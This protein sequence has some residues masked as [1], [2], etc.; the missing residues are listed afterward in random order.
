[1]KQ[2]KH[3]RPLSEIIPDES[4]SSLKTIFRVVRIGCL[5][6]IMLMVLK[7]T[8][9]HLGHS[10]ALTADGFHSLNDVAADLIMLVF[11]GISYREADERYSY[12]YGK[13]ET[14]ASFLISLFLIFVSVHIGMEG[15]ES[16]MEFAR[17]ETLSR[18]ELS[19]LVVV[20]FAMACKE[21]LFRFYS[22]AGKKAGCKPLIANAWHH[23]GDALASLATLAGVSCAHFLGEKFRILDPVASIVIAVF[24]LVPALKI[25]IPSFAELMDRALPAAQVGAARKIVAT[26]PGVEGISFM[27]THKNGH[28]LVFDVGVMVNPLLS[29]AQSDMIAAGIRQRLIDEFCRHIVVSVS[30]LPADT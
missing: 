27:R 7:L 16:I 14:F 11:V 4:E 23:R 17:G 12:G 20:V 1:M 2:K 5:V 19:T 15:V 30:V 26:T 18:P 13:F 3:H 9:G 6:N 28:H 22:R 29:V 21:A 8:V 24:I 25:M 10:E